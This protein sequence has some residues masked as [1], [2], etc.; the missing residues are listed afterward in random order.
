MK[1]LQWM[2]MLFTVALVFGCKP[3]QKAVT[4]G[5]AN[6]DLEGT[7]WKLVELN[8]QQIRPT[9]DNRREIHIQFR[10][11]SAKLEGFAGCNTIA[12]QYTV[13]E[14]NRLRISSI[15]STRMACDDLDLETA[16][17]KVLETAENYTIK[18]YGL[19]LSKGRLAPLAKFKAVYFH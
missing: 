3:K 13:D 19:S 16:L 2:V 5:Y 15:L 6:A 11:E 12:G 9:P 7:Y 4:D 8:G 10:K 1:Q 18:G 14:D 17:I